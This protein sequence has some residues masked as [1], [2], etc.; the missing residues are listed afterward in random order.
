MPIPIETVRGFDSYGVKVL[1]L[2]PGRGPGDLVEVW[3]SR[4]AGANRTEV[5]ICNGFEEV[6]SVSVED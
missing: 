3:I 1:V 5:L 6:A 2:V 4:P